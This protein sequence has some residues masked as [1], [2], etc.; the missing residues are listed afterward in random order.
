MGS[1]D[2]KMWKKPSD[3]CGLKFGGTLTGQIGLSR[4]GFH[5][6]GSALWKSPTIVWDVDSGDLNGDIGSAQEVFA[7]KAL[8]PGLLPGF[9]GILSAPGGN[10]GDLP[11][12]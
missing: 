1:T 10:I 2:A 6:D 8:L 7:G 12:L 9:T 3:V 5:K 11:T 4:A